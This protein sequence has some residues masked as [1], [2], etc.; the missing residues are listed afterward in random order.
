MYRGLVFDLD[1][2]LLDTLQDIGEAMNRVLA[3]H[4]FP[5]HRMDSYRYL[6]GR[7][8]TQLVR[9][10]LPVEA[11]REELVIQGVLADLRNEYTVQQ[12]KHTALYPGIADLLDRLSE[13]NYKLAVLSNK[14]HELTQQVV[15]RHLGRWDFVTVLGAREGVPVKPDPA[16]VYDV[17]ADLQLTGR[18]VLY[19]GDTDT[20]M[21]T[22]ERSGLVAVGV[23][24][25]FRKRDELLR[26][27]ARYIIRHPMDTLTILKGEG[28]VYCV[29]Q[30]D[31]L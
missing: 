1:G 30:I 19:L 10:A 29:R 9:S 28:E 20:D 14:P 16:A 3:R 4:G 21:Q 2:T 7:G 27:G 17:L 25:G 5:E 6:V 26:S 15:R 24:W 23:E 12:E 22:A 13:S 31:D 18:E 8:V 11:A